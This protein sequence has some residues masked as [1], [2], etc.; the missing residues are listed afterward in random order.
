MSINIFSLFQEFISC[1]NMLLSLIFN[2]LT[3]F[4]IFG[5]ALVT[6]SMMVMLAVFA[7][8]DSGF[9]SIAKS[10]LLDLKAGDERMAGRFAN[11]NWAPIALADGR[12]LIRD[13]VRMMCLKIAK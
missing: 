2:V 11:Q 12:L 6:L 3:H 1:S 9:K 4:S 13:Q 10:E 7:V 5:I 8:R